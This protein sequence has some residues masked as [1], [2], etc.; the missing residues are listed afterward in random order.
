LESEF[1]ESFR[2]FLQASGLSLRLI[3]HICSSVDHINKKIRAD[4]NLGW[5]F[6]IGHSYFCTYTSVQTE[7]TWWQEIVNFELK[8]LLHEIW[9]D[10]ISVA[11]EMAKSLGF[12]A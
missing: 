9:F 2:T 10:K 4:E 11:A 12:T 1:R 3:E 7:E 6:Q 8:P 5:E